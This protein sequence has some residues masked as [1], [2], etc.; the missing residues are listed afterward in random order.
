M[1][2]V[3]VNGQTVDVE[4][5]AKS[6]KCIMDIE[7]QLGMPFG[8][9]AELLTQGSMTAITAAVWALLRRDN[10]DL[11]FEDVEFDPTSVRQVEDPTGGGSQ[12]GTSPTTSPN[13]G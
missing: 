1:I 2:L 12:D 5:V 3:E 7:Q 6:N 13:I 9:V 11:K 8:K 4:A 10:P